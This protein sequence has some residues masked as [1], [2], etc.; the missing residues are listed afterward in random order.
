MT[1]HHGKAAITLATL[2]VT[3]PVVLA[4]PAAAQ[5]N[6][7]PRQASTV[8]LLTG[9]G[10]INQTDLRYHVHGTDLGIM[11][12]DE[13]GQLRIAFGDTFGA[14]WAG[15]SGLSGTSADHDWRSNTLARSSAQD[16]SDGLFFAD[17]V[18]DH[19]GHAKELL[20]SLK[21]DHEEISTIP[22]G[23]VH[24]AGRD[25]LAYM[26]VRHFGPHGR[27]TTNHS[28]VAYSDDDGQTWVTAPGARRPNTPA[29]DDPFQMIAYARRNGFVY[30][31]GTPN[32]RFGAA[33]LARVP[34]KKLLDQDA[35]EYWTG[36]GGWRSGDATAA[37]PIVPG[38]VGELSV[39]YDTTL[40]SW[41]MM[42]L[43][44]SRDAIVVRLARQPT[45]HWSPE[46]TIATAEQ[47]PGLYGA[48]LHPG[49]NGTEVYFTMTQ[50]SRYNVTLMRAELPLPRRAR[51]RL[52]LLA[53]S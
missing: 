15:S 7:E 34:E 48:F 30:A 26:S 21:R 6:G 5:P 53:C 51:R 35:Y 18:T 11:W 20:P 8:A 10:S 31:F 23:G 49:S 25:Y 45:G 39:R 2:A 13:D 29:F 38:P 44:E 27:W 42:Y 28:G 19:P 37:A 40:G 24:V 1:V 52:C 32:G 50:F 33:H 12:T 17:F 16:P 22:T 3:A 46:L 14:G 36:L 9:P 47:Y 41:M 43:D 4:V